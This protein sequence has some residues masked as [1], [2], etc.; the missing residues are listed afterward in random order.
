[1]L[2]VRIIGIL[3]RGLM[4]SPLSL[5]SEA[6]RRATVTIDPDMHKRCKLFFGQSIHK[7]EGRLTL[8]NDLVIVKRPPQIH[9]NP[10]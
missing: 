3:V 8:E 1:M 4:S 10:R 6:F 9:D 2:L 7:E 5:V